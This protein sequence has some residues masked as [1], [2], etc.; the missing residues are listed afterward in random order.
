MFGHH[1][2]HVAAEKVSQ[3]GDAELLG[4]G[5]M[6][7]IKPICLEMVTAQV[8]AVRSHGHP[9]GQGGRKEK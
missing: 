4:G 9:P 5:D 3:A 2:T 8:G 7:G 6:M 1:F